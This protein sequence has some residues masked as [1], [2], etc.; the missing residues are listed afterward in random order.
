M[1]K[2][3]FSPI[4]K[5]LKK[6]ILPMKYSYAGY[7]IYDFSRKMTG[8]RT[9]R[10]NISKLIGYYPDLKNP[11]SFNEKILWKKIYDRNPLLPVIADK[12]LV[13]QYV[14]RIL[15]RDETEK[16]LIPLLYMTEDPETI[17]F[18]ALTG[19][20]IIK[21]NNASQKF[22]VAENIDGSKKYTV[23]DGSKI[24]MTF[25]DSKESREKIVTICKKWLSLSYG[26]YTLEW[27]YQK[28]KRKI[29]IE[30]LLRDSM[31]RIPDDYKFNMIHGKCRMIDFC[32]NRLNGL[33]FVSYDQDWNLMPLRWDKQGTNVEKPEMLGSMLSIAE[34]LSRDFDYIRVDLYQSGKQIYF[35]ELTN[36]PL[37]GRNVFKPESYDFEVGSCWKIT[38]RYW[39]N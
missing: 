18:D 21:P 36:Y 7:L 14:G 2:N 32:S 13:R 22:I 39:K 30:K 5:S 3:P 34:K 20:F 17:P 38:P 8:Y 28:I 1:A 29:V 11:R 19:E 16:V 9:E 35:G 10:K 31:G 37:S 27:A 33:T 4:I 25:H 26:Y 6:F 12:Y 23:K 15:G 24:K